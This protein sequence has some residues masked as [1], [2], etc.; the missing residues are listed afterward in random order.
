M[1]D[2]SG[3]VAVENED[4]ATALLAFASGVKGVMTA[5]RSA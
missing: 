2:G 3:V 5:S 4:T 1:T